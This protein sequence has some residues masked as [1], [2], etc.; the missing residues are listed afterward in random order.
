MGAYAYCK[1]K[2][3]PIPMCAAQGLGTRSPCAGQ[4]AFW[5]YALGMYAKHIPTRCPCRDDRKAGIAAALPVH[6]RSAVRT[7]RLPTYIGCMLRVRSL[8]RSTSRERPLCTYSVARQNRVIANGPS[9]WLLLPR[10]I[11]IVR[12]SAPNL[13]MYCTY[14]LYIPSG[15]YSCVAWEFREGKSTWQCTYY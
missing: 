4:Y 9:P 2:V 11:I 6:G 10:W 1:F 8:L 3:G 14:C 13:C 15:H 5:L 7:A 12:L